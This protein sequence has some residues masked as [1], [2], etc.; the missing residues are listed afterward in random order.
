MIEVTHDTFEFTLSHLAMGKLNARAGHQIGNLL[1][2]F[3]NAGDF[4]GETMPADTAVSGDNYGSRNNYG[5]QVFG[6]SGYSVALWPDGNP[7]D[8]LPFLWARLKREDCQGFA[9]HIGLFV[10]PD[11]CNL[12]RR[13]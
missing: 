12:S 5:G 8:L 6:K 11:F 13:I 4:V 10:S 3:L 1:R 9:T 2:G 7:D